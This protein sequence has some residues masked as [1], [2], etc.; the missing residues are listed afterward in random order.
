[1]SEMFSGT[2]Y[3]TEV[4]SINISSWSAGIHGERV[5]QRPMWLSHKEQ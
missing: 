3:S 5:M 4:S 2:A 1:M